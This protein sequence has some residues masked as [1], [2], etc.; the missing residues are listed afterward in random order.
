MKHRCLFERFDDASRTSSSSPAFTFLDARL[1]PTSY[2]SRQVI[3]Q[4]RELGRKLQS[5]NI[6]P[7]RPLS[8]L[9]QS[10]EAQ[11]LHYLAALYSGVTPAIL[12]PPHRKLHREYYLETTRAIFQTCDFSAV[13]TDVADLDPG[14][15]TLEPYTLTVR[16]LGTP[17]AQV[18]HPLQFGAQAFLQFTSGTTGIKRGVLVSHE[19][20]LAQV[21][22]YSDAIGLTDSDCIVSWLPLYHDMGLMTSL[23][24]ALACGVHSV[25]LD[26]VHW[27]SRPG[28]YLH[29][30]TQYRGTLGWNPNFAFKFMADR[31][32][33]ED[34]AGVDLSSIRGLVN[35]SE[36]VTW[37]SQQSF[38][39]RF[40]PFRLRE[41]AFW[42]CYAMAE[43]TF[44]ITH[45][46]FDSPDCY[47]TRV[48][49]G[50]SRSDGGGP[51]ISVGSPLPGVELRIRAGAEFV[52]DRKLGELWVRSPFNFTGY[53][54]NPEATATAVCDGWYK[55]GDL[56]YKVGDRFFVS[57]R[58]KDMLI[59]GGVNI[60]P[61]DIEELVS[62]ISGV[63]SGRVCAFAL[64]DPET[65][66]ERAV[67]IAETDLPPEGRPALII[68][69]RQAIA[70]SFQISHFTVE[71]TEVGYLVK[72]SAGKMA[73]R[74]NRERWQRSEL[75]G[76][77]DAG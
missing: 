4:A 57:G 40:R 13:V 41:E 66:T 61:E 77:R 36:P 62:A 8:I 26:P 50:L 56:G 21:A 38:Q 14:I 63:H 24:M 44:A 27:V 46:R 65:Q 58:A 42:G 60:F 71:L 10:Q 74:A 35:C 75:T 52:E 15:T 20:A 28:L 22:A 23:N 48:V 51:R 16:P 49:N 12:A 30:I 34:L 64:F 5:A 45:G 25:M 53:Y 67:V 7:E 11:V 37:L 69:I 3:D 6:D 1:N 70:A 17:P 43:T 55:T 33:D 72:S 68:R 59:V 19:A 18:K 54:N 76:R 73:R 47:D 31:I 32:P 2:T 29:A 39:N 9:V